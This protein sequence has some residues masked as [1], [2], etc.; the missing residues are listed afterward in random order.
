MLLG[1]FPGYDGKP[2]CLKHYKSAYFY[3]E[4]GVQPSHHLFIN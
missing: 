4:F 1:Y 2:Q 3:R